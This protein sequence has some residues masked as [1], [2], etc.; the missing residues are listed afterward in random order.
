MSE[1]DKPF[2][3]R[4]AAL[5]F[6]LL[7]NNRWFST[8]HPIMKPDQMRSLCVDWASAVDGIEHTYDVQ[9]ATLAVLFGMID[10]PHWRPHIVL[11]KLKLLRYFMSAP[12]DSQPHPE[13]GWTR[14]RT[15]QIRRLCSAGGRTWICICQ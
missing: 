2:Q 8:P 6:L 15:P 14:S 4:E 3:L 1:D 10:S 5:F 7:I 12:D 13:L 9:K 11:E